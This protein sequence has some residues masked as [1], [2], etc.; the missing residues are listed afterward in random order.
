M[1]RLETGG[2]GAWKDGRSRG[3]SEPQ[4]YTGRS[5]LGAGPELLVANVRPEQGWDLHHKEVWF[6]EG[7]PVARV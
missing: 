5:Q 1:E 2:G 6:L 7:T 3:Q 4:V